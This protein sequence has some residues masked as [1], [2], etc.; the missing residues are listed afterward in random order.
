MKKC[1]KCLCLKST[2]D[3]YKGNCSDGFDSYCKQ[4]GKQTSLQYNRRLRMRAVEKLG[5]M[6]VECGI[7]DIRVLQ[8][9]HIHGGGSK[10]FKKIGNRAVYRKIIAGEV[11]EF[12]LLCA[13]CNWIKRFEQEEHGNYLNTRD[14]E[15]GT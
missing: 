6:C 5:S 13:N 9:D 8:I 10:E 1:S 14:Q 11:G 2:Q 4:C 15:L 7:E 12:Q 3:F